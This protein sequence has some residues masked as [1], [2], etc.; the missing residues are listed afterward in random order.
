MSVPDRETSTS[1]VQDW[2][3]RKTNLR[4]LKP[5]VPPLKL[6]ERCGFAE[7]DRHCFGRP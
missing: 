7:R 5:K 6:S 3:S 2:H 4:S 1:Y